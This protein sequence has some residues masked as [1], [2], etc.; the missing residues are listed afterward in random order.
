MK[1]VFKSRFLHSYKFSVLWIILIFSSFIFINCD[2]NIEKIPIITI[3][4][5]PVPITHTTVGY[6]S[7]NLSVVASVTNNASLVYQWYSNS[8][9][10]NTSGVQVPGAT[11][12][13]SINT[14]NAAEWFLLLLL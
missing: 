4:T 11:L 3:D 7:G 12:S 14:N 8:F 13:I 9:A 5:Q 1:K 2:E 6:I 10:D